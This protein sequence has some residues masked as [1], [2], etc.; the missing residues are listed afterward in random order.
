MCYLCTRFVPIQSL[1]QRVSCRSVLSPLTPDEVGPYIERRLEVAQRGTAVL[2]A[3]E[4]PPPTVKFTPAAVEVIADVSGGIP[5]A[6]N[7]VCACALEIGYEREVRSLDRQ[8]AV[9]AARQV[10][11]TVPS[12]SGPTRGRPIA[13][14]MWVAGV[15]AVAVDC[16]VADLRSPLAD[17]TRTLQTDGGHVC[18]TRRPRRKRL[19]PSWRRPSRR[20]PKARCPPLTACFLSWGLLRVASARAPSRARSERAACRPSPVS[21]PPAIRMSCWSARMSRAR[22]R[23]KRSDRSRRFIIQTS[24]LCPSVADV[25]SARDPTRSIVRRRQALCGTRGI[26]TRVSLA[27]AA[28]SATGL[29]RAS[30]LSR[31]SERCP[32]SEPQ[33]S[34]GSSARTLVGFSMRSFR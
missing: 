34:R 17:G 8:V 22:R 31:S 28:C 3:H 20:R 1:D 7:E 13:M 33:P 11:L 24:G 27:V 16:L 6:V 26:L 21:M 30:L 25:E 18:E 10:G 12:P 19:R 5:R 32:A 9:A 23:S 15:T 4:Q 29:E 14:T 2:A